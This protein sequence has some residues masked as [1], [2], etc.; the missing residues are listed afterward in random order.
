MFM[1]LNYARTNTPVAIPV[2]LVKSFWSDE[3]ANS[4]CTTIEYVD[5]DIA[6]VSQSFSQV[7]EA[8]D[9]ASKEI[10]GQV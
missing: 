7:V 1:I 3:V 4:P 6:H 10:R 5:G 2:N 9:K 8:A